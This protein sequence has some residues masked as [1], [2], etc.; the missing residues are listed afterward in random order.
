MALHPAPHSPLTAFM[1]V[2]PEGDANGLKDRG[3]LAPE[4]VA[5]LRALAHPAL[6]FRLI[7]A[8]PEANRILLSLQDARWQMDLV[9]VQTNRW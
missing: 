9:T 3:A 5:A 6:A 7:Q 1:E 4:W 8:A 2:P